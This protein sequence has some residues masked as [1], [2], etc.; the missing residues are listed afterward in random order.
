[1]LNVILTTYWYFCPWGVLLH[2]LQFIPTCCYEQIF[3]SRGQWPIH[4][5]IANEATHEMGGY[6]DWSSWRTCFSRMTC[7]WWSM[8]K[9]VLFGSPSFWQAVCFT[10]MKKGT[11]SV[12]TLALDASVFVKVCVCMCVH[13]YIYNTRVHIYTAVLS[14][15]NCIKTYATV[16]GT[17]PL[18][19]PSRW[20]CGW[21]PSG[22]QPSRW[23]FVRRLTC[24]ML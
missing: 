21:K 17:L 4:E 2:A 5:S 3:C 13:I 16:R 7:T 19:M 10:I 24:P 11:S 23:L 9:Q 15:S 14:S 1:M 6:H 12:M 20:S 18:R 22:Q 8:L